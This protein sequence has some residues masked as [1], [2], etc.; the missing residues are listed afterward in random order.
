MLN[1]FYAVTVYSGSEEF[2]SKS[3]YEILIEN[4]N[5][6]VKKI[7]LIGKSSI[8]VGEEL[9]NGS[10]LAVSNSCGLQLYYPHKGVRMDDVNTKNFGGGS[11]PI[12]GLFKTR[13]SAKKC[14]DSN[15]PYKWDKRFMQ[16][17][18]KILKE[19]GVQTTEPVRLD[20]YLS[21]A[22]SENKISEYL[23]V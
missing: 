15:T 5:V 21:R 23:R 11:A 19:I 3:I 7:A 13:D 4:N 18:R 2:D 14:F 20:S 22:V 8:K 10:V 16:S 12:V 6:V 9:T 17:T 1:K